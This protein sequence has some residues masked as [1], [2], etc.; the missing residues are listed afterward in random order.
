MGGNAVKKKRSPH[1][2]WTLCFSSSEKNRVY[3][4]LGLCFF[5]S[6]SPPCLVLRAEIFR[7]L[8]SSLPLIRWSQ[9]LGY[10]FLASYVIII[11]TRPN[12]F[13]TAPK[14][15]NLMLMFSCSHDLML[16]FSDSSLSYFLLY[17][18]ARVSDMASW[19]AMAL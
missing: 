10:G 8:S 17:A 4:N 11:C 1:F 5:H 18:G 3:K 9:G 14:K 7:P 19:H 15:S 6:I 2:L 12:F 16:K 13:K